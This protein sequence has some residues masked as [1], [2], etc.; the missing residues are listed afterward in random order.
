[1]CFRTER[2]EYRELNHKEECLPAVEEA[3]DPN[4]SFSRIMFLKTAAAAASVFAVFVSLAMSDKRILLISALGLIFIMIPSILLEDFRDWCYS[5]FD[6]KAP[7][8][9]PMN[10]V[11]AS[12]AAVDA[13]FGAAMPVPV[14][15]SFASFRAQAVR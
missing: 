13:V 5:L 2:S 10:P 8:P 6:T 11:I 15:G 12:I 3:L 9:L 4:S 1:M 14:D 7:P